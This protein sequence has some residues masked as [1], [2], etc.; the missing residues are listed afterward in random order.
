MMA[1]HWKRLARGRRVALVWFSHRHNLSHLGLEHDA[2]RANVQLE[3]IEHAL[4]RCAAMRVIRAPTYIYSR[5]T[6]MCLEKEQPFDLFILDTEG[7][8]DRSNAALKEELEHRD[9][10]W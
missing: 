9:L 3:K 2:N 5:P 4:D 1:E 10:I 8:H 7:H 6:R